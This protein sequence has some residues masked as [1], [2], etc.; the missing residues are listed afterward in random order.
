MVSLS[1]LLK[2]LWA[3]QNSSDA[4]SLTLAH[5][6]QELDFDLVWVGLYDRSRH[7][8]VTH[9]YRSSTSLASPLRNTINLSPG[10][11][12]EQAVV[13]RRPLIVADL[14]N[15]IRAGE[16]GQMAREYALQSAIIYPLKRQEVCFGLLVLASPRWGLTSSLA[17]RSYLA[18]VTAALAEVLHRFDQDQQQQRAKRLEQPLISLVGRLAALDRVDDQLREAVQAIQQLIEPTRTR[19]FWFESQGNYFWQRQPPLPNLSPTPSAEPALHLPV[20]EMRGLFQAFANQPLVVLGDRQGALNALV[21]DRVMQ[22]LQAQ[23]SMVLPLTR[24]A[25][26]L[27]F[28]SVES[29][30]PRLWEEYEKQFLI[31]IAQLLNLALPMAAHQE[32]QRHHQMDAYLTA[33]VVQGIHNDSDWHHALQ[34]CFETLRDRLAIQ[35]FLVLLHHPDRQG[36]EL[37]FQGQGKRTR[38]AA[39][40]WPPLDA[41]DE[42]LLERHPSPVV[43]DSLIQDLKLLAWRPPLIDLEAQAVMASNVAPGHAP[44]GVV[45]VTDGLSRQWTAAEQSLLQTL[46]RQIGSLL[47]QWQLQRQIGQQRGAYAALEAGLKALHHGE[48]TDQLESVT[49]QYFLDSLA[50]STACLILWQS[51]ENQAQIAHLVSQDARGMI[52]ADQ[53]IALAH[54]ALLQSALQAEGPLLRPINELSPT[55]RTWIT[56][57]GDHWMLIS[58]LRTAPRHRV[59]G[60]VAV[61]SATAQPWSS[62]QVNLFKVLTEQ[63]AWSRRQRQLTR[64]L[65]QQRQDL[66]HL[67]WYKNRQ[68]EETQRTLY[69]LIQAF[70]LAMGQDAGLTHHQGEYF[71]SQLHRL[72][73][74]GQTLLDQ[75]R[76]QLQNHG[77]TIPLITLLNRLIER[78]TPVLEQRQL[79]SKVHNQSHALLVGNI[80]KFE[81][82]ISEVLLA[83]CERSPVGGRIDLWCRVLNSSWLELSITDSGQCSQ[84]LLQDLKGAPPLDLLVPSTLDQPPGRHLAICK[85]LLD[86]LG[87]E[88]T[89]S[90]LED[91]R[92]HSRLLLPLESRSNPA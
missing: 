90:R 22:Q 61:V 77:Q 35:Q 76:W 83:A 55:T 70:S 16:W 66:E 11:L 92:T 65:A 32:Q 42:R 46:A 47:N 10:D 13:Q 8:L 19:V 80:S 34:T 57:P 62:D 86:Q 63:L 85:T 52:Q 41:V 2:A 43:V 26:P 15:E 56:A 58:A 14:Q 29:S 78:I 36:Y 79:W 25:D 44:A 17:E 27:G 1:R 75:E 88:I 59:M 3:A 38:P 40:F 5:C 68:I 53:P 39:S 69:Q 18:I 7:R 9:G 4:I 23:S 37:C 33:G 73:E 84:A 67:N 82:I 64:L 12:M 50:A 54:E 72:V 6:H 28:L 20:D 89:F 21:S 91:G 60:F 30:L 87:G 71:L 31:G 48:A 81:L 24:G 51:G 45:V 74:T 49:L